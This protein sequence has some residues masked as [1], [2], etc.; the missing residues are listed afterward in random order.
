MIRSFCL[1]AVMAAAF[2]VPAHAAMMWDIDETQSSLKV[3]GTF[4]LD[5]GGGP[6]A[7]SV[8]GIFKAWEAD[9]DFD[10]ADLATSH[11]I[12]QVDTTSLDTGVADRDKELRTPEWF[13]PAQFKRAKFEST[14]IT[15]KSGN[16]YEAVGKLTIRGVA[17][18]MVLPFTVVMTGNQADATGTFTILRSEFVVGAGTRVESVANEVTVT[19]SIK[20][21]SL[22]N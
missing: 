3:N 19:F 14:S 10:P 12:V 1:A 4:F 15:S 20:A 2:A 11:I 9:I 8:E 7:N 18:D 22:T 5:F 16:D 17:K 6:M 21:T 13:D